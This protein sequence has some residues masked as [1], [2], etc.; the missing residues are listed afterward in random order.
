MLFP[1]G[2]LGSRTGKRWILEDEGLVGETAIIVLRLDSQ[3]RTAGGGRK[4]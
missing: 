2:F 3:E 1:L 4:V